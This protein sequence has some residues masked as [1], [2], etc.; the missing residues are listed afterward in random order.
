MTGTFFFAMSLFLLPMASSITYL[1]GVTTGIAIGHSLVLAPLNGL[2]SKSVGESSQGKVLG[3]MQSASSFAR[4][5]GPVLGGLLLNYD[6]Q[7]LARAFGKTAYSAGGVI[8]LV[9]FFLAMAL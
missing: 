1:L 2:A 5:L 8:T 6:L 7:H 4:I 9:A 3:M